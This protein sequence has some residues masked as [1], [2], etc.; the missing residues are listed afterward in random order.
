M[1][2][3]RPDASRPLRA[4]RVGLGIVGLNV[5]LL[6]A[7]APAAEFPA[8]SQGRPGFVV[9]VVAVPA[10][11]GSV[12]VDV[13]WDVPYRELTFRKDGDWHRARYDVAA[14]FHRDDRQV[15][16]DVWPAR[17]RTKDFDATRR[18][19]ER[20]RG[21][22]SVVLPAGDYDV[23]VTLTDRGSHASSLAV[24]KLRADF[25]ASGIGLSDLRL[26]RYRGETAASNPG[27]DLRVGEDGHFVR[28]EL[29]PASAERSAVRVKWRVL[30]G[31]RETLVESD[32]SVVVEGEPLRL[33]LP[34]ATD[35]LKV[36]QLEMEVRAETGGNASDRRTT[37]LNVHL[38]ATWFET[39]REEAL[40]VLS[41][42]ATDEEKE[43]L[44]AAS[45][46]EWA[47]AVS[48]FWRGRDPDP[49]T[50]ENEFRTIFQ[51]RMELAA[52]WFVEPFRHP[53]WRT[54]R[55]RVL[56]EYGRPARRS[57]RGADFERP[58]AEVWE[59][60][61]PR[62]TFY[63]VDVQGTGEFWLRG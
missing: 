14:V 39:R 57:V 55:G 32:S 56:L 61:A 50:S 8:R 2:F 13:A 22:R 51:Q 36:G 43:R 17:V 5:L 44:R 40:E 47:D 42:V 21:R 23:R 45:E 34:L 37:R 9:N 16:G 46:A 11:P 30:D 53:G 12:R 28:V 49:E 10:S 35:S 1:S 20:A 62:R 60:D 63:F 33:D 54:D 25:A 7:A 15:G 4:V 19:D 29:H 48:A 52:T 58:A 41:L 26:V 38:G 31:S 18:G 3:G 6:A 24:G 59:Y 27:H